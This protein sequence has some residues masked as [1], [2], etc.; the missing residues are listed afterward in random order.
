M[1]PAKGKQ[2]ARKPELDRKELSR[3]FDC[4]LDNEFIR[5]LSGSH[6]SFQKH[7]RKNGDLRAFG[8]EAHPYLWA[9]SHFRLE[10]PAS[11]VE[12]CHSMTDFEAFFQRENMPSTPS[13]DWFLSYGVRGSFTA[14]HTDPLAESHGFLCIVKGKKLLFYWKLS[15]HVSAEQKEEFLTAASTEL[16]FDGKDEADGF[17]DIDVSVVRQGFHRF[18]LASP[19]VLQASVV[20]L[21]AGQAIHFNASN[22][23]AVINLSDCMAVS[24]EIWSKRKS[25]R[26]LN[27][28]KDLAA[29]EQLLGKTKEGST[30]HWV[31]VNFEKIEKYWPNNHER[32]RR[33]GYQS[34]ETQKRT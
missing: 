19:I 30:S 5:D 9:R 11:R 25:Q 24:G 15:E 32:M 3:Q 28:L 21:C 22:P 33:T 17:R 7:F 4:E 10:I 20:P 18:S 34:V 8:N 29:R 12:K 1:E 26:L 14:P 6:E 27:E 13:L 16:G 23:H 2:K 31:L